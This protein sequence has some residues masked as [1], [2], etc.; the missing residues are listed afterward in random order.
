[1]GDGNLMLLKYSGVRAGSNYTSHMVSIIISEIISHSMSMMVVVLVDSPM[2]SFK[3]S[4]N[5]KE[6]HFFG[7]GVF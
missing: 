5:H 3:N 6:Q 1:M 4:L 2:K 7:L